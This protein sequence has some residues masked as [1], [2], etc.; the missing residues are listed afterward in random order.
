MSDKLTREK[1]I[2][3]ARELATPI[4][5]DEL[6]AKGILIR[7]SA[8]WYEVIDFG[9]LPSHASR[10]KIKKELIKKWFSSDNFH[11]IPVR[12]DLAVQFS[13]NKTALLG[14]TLRTKMKPAK[15]NRGG[16]GVPR[17]QGLLA[18][19]FWPDPI[20]PRSECRP[21]LSGTDATRDLESHYLAR[22]NVPN[23]VRAS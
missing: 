17:I 14:K 18:F 19:R 1:I 5:F 4:D 11:F 7:R 8:Q 9:A 20:A 21:S 10:K 15:P 6:I 3:L 16:F 23:V 13:M 2:E 12:R 22:G